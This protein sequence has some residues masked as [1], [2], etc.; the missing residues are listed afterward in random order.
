M[1]RTVHCAKLDADL[2]GLDRPP[3]PGELGQK[4]FENVSKDAWTQ[5]LAPQTMLINQY[6]LAL[7]DRKARD[8]L[9]KEMDNDVLAR[10][11]NETGQ[12]PPVPRTK[13]RRPRRRHR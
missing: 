10:E 11:L 3:V 2:P 6:R 8:F 13:P 12:R 9:T 7:A 1:T 5:W 4:I